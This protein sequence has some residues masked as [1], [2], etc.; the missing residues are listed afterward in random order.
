LPDAL[1]IVARVKN[2]DRGVNVVEIDH[3]LPQDGA[4][5]RY[6]TGDFRVLLDKP[7]K[8]VWPERVAHRKRR[9]DGLRCLR[10][11]EIDTLMQPVA[12]RCPAGS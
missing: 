12:R 2:P 9:R 1:D 5:M 7:D 6:L 10:K 4:V 11:T 8:G 3:Q